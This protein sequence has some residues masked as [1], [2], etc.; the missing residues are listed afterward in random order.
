[1]PMLRVVRRDPGA[2]G[3]R[4]ARSRPPMT[5]LAAIGPLQPGDAAQRRGLAAARRAEQR[6]ELPLLDLE[7]DALHRQMLAMSGA[8]R[9]REIADPDHSI[10]PKRGLTRP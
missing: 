8:V 5:M 10:P 9:H 6:E 7:R 1:M 3:A 2:A 4:T